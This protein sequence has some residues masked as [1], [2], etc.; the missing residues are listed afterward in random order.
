MGI[1]FKTGIVVGALLMHWL[2]VGCFVR[3]FRAATDTKQTCYRGCADRITIGELPL[4]YILDL[5]HI[6]QNGYQSA[7]C[8]TT[9]HPGGWYEEA[10]RWTGCEDSTLGGPNTTLINDHK[11]VKEELLSIA[12]RERDGEI[13]RGN[14]F[15]M[16]PNSPLFWEDVEPRAVGLGMSA[17]QREVIRPIL[18]KMLSCDSACEDRVAATLREY[19]SK[20]DRFDVFPDLI[21]LIQL[22]LHNVLFPEDSYP[23]DFAEFQEAQTSFFTLQVPLLMLPEFA[24]KRLSAKTRAVLDKHL[25]HYQ[26]M[27]QKYYGVDLAALSE[28][29]C[30]P[31]T[32]CL[33]QLSHTVLDV[34]VAPGGL[35]MPHALKAGLF[36]M[37]ADTEQYLYDKNAA[38]SAENRLFPAQAAVLAEDSAL[39]FWEVIRFFTPVSTF[40]YWDKSP[41]DGAKTGRKHTHINLFTADKDPNVWGKDHAKFRVKDLKLYKEEFTGFADFATDSDLGNKMDHACPGKGLA[42]VIGK[43]FFTHFTEKKWELEGTSPEFVGRLPYITGDFVIK[44]V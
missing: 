33:V 20:R 16:L 14:E 13:W 27:T 38:P 18:A 11:R 35:S 22:V 5:A 32:S 37:F 12:K 44:R 7:F 6:L 28:D 15:A 39:Y 10:G 2:N 26:K 19:I 21:A 30:A 17:T 3:C 31:T 25:A 24:A 34:F 41:K 43:H 23:F 8:N 9:E 29:A 40:P 1:L 42:M 4:T 36:V